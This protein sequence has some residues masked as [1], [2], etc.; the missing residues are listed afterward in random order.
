ML[1]KSERNAVA[2]AVELNGAAKVER[3]QYGVYR[4][5]APRASAATS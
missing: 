1:N 4:C 3:V 2:K 5:R